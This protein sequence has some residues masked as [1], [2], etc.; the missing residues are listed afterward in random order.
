MTRVGRLAAALVVVLPALAGAAAAPVPLGP[1][2]PIARAHDA[3]E[4][5]ASRLR[6]LGGTPLDRIGL[7]AWTNGVAHPIPFQVDER[8]GSH[9]AMPNGPE[10]DRDDQ[11]GILDKDDAF[12]FMPCDAGERAPDGAPPAALG[13]EIRLDDPRT[14]RTAWAYVMLG[15]APPRTDR[16]YVAYDAAHDIVSTATWRV[17]CVG[18]LPSYFALGLAGS[19]GPNLVDG[20]RLRAEAT[21]R[22]NLAHWTLDETEGRHRLVAWTEG[23]IRVMRRSRHEVDIGLGIHL[24]AG[25]AH[26]AFYAEH[27]LAPGSLHLPFSPSIFFKDITAIGGVDLHLPPGWRYVAPGTPAAGFAIDGTMNDAERGFTAR[28]DWFALVHDGEAVMVVVEMSENLRRAL[29]LGLVYR[30]DAAH[31]APPERERGQ[32]PLV[33]MQA[34]EV[35][36][37]EPARYRFQL[38]IVMLHGWSA[39][40]ADGVRR[41]VATPLTADVTVPP[42][43]PSP[44]APGAPAATAPPPRGAPAVT[45]PAAPA[46]APARRR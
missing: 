20:L 35:Q 16:R 12:L 11:P 10:A 1:C 6:R 26:T 2:G 13:R 8:V 15:D 43:W 19:L 45:A 40:T 39:A 22:G 3:V 4:L 36:N 42:D 44:P 37:L 5:T 38:R 24:T 46:A 30:D 28:G 18:A 27:V 34:R 17:G 31:A 33:A 9:V 41:D 7:V 23:A 32:M 29:P 14:G 25:V 21:L